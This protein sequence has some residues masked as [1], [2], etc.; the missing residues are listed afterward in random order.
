MSELDPQTVL[1]R[2]QRAK[3]RRGAWESHW[4]DCV[5]HTLP[6]RAAGVG[7]AEPG[8]QRHERLFDATAGDAAEQ[9]AAS[10]L[11]EL[12]P[13]WSRWFGLTPGAA[14][15]AADR[16][17]LT[18][19][20]A[21]A[22]TVVQ[23]HLDR[24]NLATE[25]HQCYLDLVTVGTACLLFEEAPVGARSAFRFTAVPMREAV[26]DEGPHGQLDVV[27]RATSMTPDQLA[28]RYGADA[29]PP[30][31]A[32]AAEGRGDDTRHSV[33]EAVIPDGH[34]YSYMAVLD[35]AMDGGEPIQLASGRFAQSPFI[36]FRWMKAPG[37]TYGR[38]PVMRALPDIK[39][40]NKVVELTL[41]NASIAVSGIWQADDDGVLN[42]ASIQLAPGT[43][44][45]KAMGSNGLQPL[46]TP[47]S[48]D[49]SDLVLSDLRQRI[50][51]AMLVD[52]LGAGSRTDVTATEVLERSAE[53][54]RVLGATY[55]RLQA[56]LLTPLIQ[57]AL[58]VLA[59]RG[60]V[61]PFSL[62]GRFVELQHRSPLAQVQ[63][64]KDVANTVAW[65][66]RVAQVGQ[67]GLDAV[68]IPETARWLGRTL[69]VPD[70]LMRSD[71]AIT[72]RRVQRQQ[73]AEADAPRERPAASEAAQG[74][75]TSPTGRVADG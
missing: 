16:E 39:T 53:V 21:T 27:F 22:E 48:F 60:E 37:E 74:T 71:A 72:E 68:D 36:A 67:A 2:F 29:L 1:T 56:E 26:L 43:I 15:D 59:R 31:L 23:G 42:P 58:A 52:Q 35:R 33:V 62:D 11:A 12:T 55:G 25:L 13:P 44:I 69:G 70:E 6:Q 57:R 5:D 46:Q 9:L 3:E 32:E 34:A 17:A 61:E 7:M 65:I 63:A 73:Q 19:R 50:R 8:G 66:E 54:T 45:P 14:L 10:L 49:V 64:R 20:L 38:S 47:G 51:S 24:S 40:A 41:K 30:T 4:Q 28:A 18:P 75:A